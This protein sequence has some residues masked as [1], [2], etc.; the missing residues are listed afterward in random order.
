M[1]KG[2]G[3]GKEGAGAKNGMAWHTTDAML[4]AIRYVL[5]PILSI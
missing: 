4:G 5:P 2:K 3:K 1:G